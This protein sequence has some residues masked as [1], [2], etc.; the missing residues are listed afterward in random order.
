MSK[1]DETRQRWAE[2]FDK[3]DS[4]GNGKLTIQE[5]QASLKDMGAEVSDADVAVSFV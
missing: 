5:L 3:F 2:T 4:S 1:V